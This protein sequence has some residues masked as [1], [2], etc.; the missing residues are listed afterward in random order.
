MERRN[1]PTLVYWELRKAAKE[2]QDPWPAEV[3]KPTALTDPSH[4]SDMICES[5]TEL[6]TRALTF[7]HPKQGYGDPVLLK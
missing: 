1:Q 3:V 6:L 4:S 2:A 7:N 5:Y